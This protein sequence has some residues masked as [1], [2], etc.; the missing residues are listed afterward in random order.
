MLAALAASPALAAPV[1]FAQYY[2]TGG[3]QDWAI[4]TVF[5]AVT[6][7]TTTTI[8]AQSNAAYFLFTGVSGLPVKGAEL[9]N[10]NLTATSSQI[11]NCGVKCGPGSSFSQ[12]GF[13]GTFS[14]IDA[15]LHPGAN[16][17]SG[18][19]AVT[20]APGT[21]G[22]QFSSSVGG[23]GA[24]FNGSATP[25]N[26]Q[27]LILTSDYIDFIGE[28]QANA[29]FALS[30]LIPPFATGPVTQDGNNFLAFPALGT[31]EAAAVGTFSSDP[32]PQPADEPP[33]FALFGTGLAGLGL[34]MARARFAGNRLRA[35][36]GIGAAQPA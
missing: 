1:T 6:D 3:G 30:S 25:G 35:P 32:G 18:I 4:T 29:S 31:F 24:S 23:S 34:L 5:N 27:Q 15:S 19:F 12:A 9:A 26:L 16:L 13:V 33:A 8:T 20:A 22:A 11:G 28:T 17:L 36:R 14:F 7:I 21:T 2:E 10:F